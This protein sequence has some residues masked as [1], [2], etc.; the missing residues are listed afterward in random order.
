MK[1]NITSNLKGIAYELESEFGNRKQLASF[2]CMHALRALEE[3]SGR[4]S[5]KSVV[6]HSSLKVTGIM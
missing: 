3:V 2:V 6:G 4:V 1:Y 5:G